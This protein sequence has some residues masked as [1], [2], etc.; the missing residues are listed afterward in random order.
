MAVFTLPSELMGF[1][2]KHLDFITEEAVA[3]DKRRYAS[4]FEAV[5]HYID[6]DHWG[7]APFD[8]LP[9]NWL[10]ALAFS[11]SGLPASRTAAAAMAF[12]LNDM[13]RPGAA[14]D[15]PR[16]GMGEIIEALVRGVEQGNNG[17]KVN[18][19]QPYKKLYK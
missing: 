15:Y 9:R 5:R 10:D 17:S 18:L 7:E 3:P 19:F 12:V 16:G 4:K 2:K 1:Y 11:L 8:S 14:L 6:L 13:H